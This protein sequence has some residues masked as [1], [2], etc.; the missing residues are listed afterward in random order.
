MEKFAAENERYDNRGLQFA[1]LLKMAIRDSRRNGSR[2]FLFISS[3]ILGIAALVAIYSLSNNLRHE[4]DKQAANLIGADLEI[5]GNK[6]ATGAVRDLIDTL[7]DRKSEERRFASMVYFPKTGGTRLIQVRALQGEFPYYGDLET[8]P[9][10]AGRTFRNAQMALID[11]TLMLQFD[12][13]V[14]D[15]VKVG[16]VTFIIAGTLAGAP[17]QTGL[18]ASVAPVVYI[19]LKYLAQTGLQQK[20]STIGYRYYFKYD[21]PVDVQ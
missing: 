18:S 6:P 15:S 2:L 12:A 3:I 4:I 16:D 19:P 8:V 7:G 10:S 20:G 9:A 17:G 21:R 11:Q 14:G 1:W 13:K 5:T